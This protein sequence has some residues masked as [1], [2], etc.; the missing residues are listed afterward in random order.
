MSTE[1]WA[2]WIIAQ[3][4]IIEQLRDEV[5][6]ISN[7]RLEASDP[8]RLSRDRDFERM[9]LSEGSHV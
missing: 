6:D 3:V 1:R 7:E 8:L 4:D 2:S 5:P 9:A